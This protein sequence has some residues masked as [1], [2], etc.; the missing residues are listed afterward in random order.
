[1]VCATCS[2]AFMVGYHGFFAF[3]LFRPSMS[4]K[5]TAPETH[6]YPHNTAWKKFK[7]ILERRLVNPRALWKR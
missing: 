6:N 1:M 3:I 4:C 5:V 7:A 2:A